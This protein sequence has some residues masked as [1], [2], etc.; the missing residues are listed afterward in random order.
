[1]QVVPKNG[2]PHNKLCG[3]VLTNNYSLLSQTMD[4]GNIAEKN[5]SKFT[6]VALF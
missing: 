3:S 5:A 2:I 4:K 1:M 6:T